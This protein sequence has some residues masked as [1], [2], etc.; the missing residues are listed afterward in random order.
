[1]DQSQAGFSYDPKTI[2]TLRKSLSSPRFDRYLTR[3]DG[4]DGLALELYFYNIRL[5]EAFL[6]PLGVTEVVFRNAIDEALVRSFGEDWHQPGE[7]RDRVLNPASH[8]S[9][10]TAIWRIQSSVRND[11]I[12]ALT[13]DFWSNLFRREYADLWRSNV[14][15]A[16]PGL[17]SGVGRGSIHNLVAEINKFRNRVA[18]HEPILDSN[19]RDVLSKMFRLTELRCSV[20]AEWMRQNTKVVDVMYSRPRPGDPGR[21]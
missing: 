1:M 16:F 20:T 10:T 9:L 13:F 12:A 5:A 4:D 2:E 7:F 19:F 6:Y 18:H 21:S 3:A 11:V 15:I 8:N 17:P 14:Y